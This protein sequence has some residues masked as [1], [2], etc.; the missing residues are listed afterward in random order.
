MK[1]KT[2]GRT[3]MYVTASAI[4]LTSSALFISSC[5]KEDVIDQ[6]PTNISTGT[7]MV[8]IGGSSP[9]WTIDKTHSNVGWETFYFGSN[10]LLTGRFNNFGVTLHFDQENPENTTINS[11]VQLSTFNTGE[12]GRDAA[13]K[14]GPGYMGVVFDVDTNPTP[15]V[16]TVQ[17]ATDTAWFNSISTE[18]FGSGYVA[19]GTLNF[20][21]VEAPIDLYFEYSGITEYASTTGGA[22]TYKTGFS[23]QFD[24]KA[25]S[26]FGVTSTSI[27]DLVKVK[28]NVNA[29]KI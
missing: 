26:V 9:T 16:Y 3:W 13:G 5:N 22:P 2:T 29:K 23:G 7:D 19:H 24:M 6:F 20:K 27:A 25:Q 18:R 15:D 28:I 1:T 8:D 10:A 17:P 4:L 12:P 21:N 14:C 11:W